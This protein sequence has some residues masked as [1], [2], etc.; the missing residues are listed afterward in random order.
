[1]LIENNIDITNFRSNST[2][3]TLY[4]DNGRQWGNPLLQDETMRH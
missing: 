4:D 3:Q 1:L 2:K